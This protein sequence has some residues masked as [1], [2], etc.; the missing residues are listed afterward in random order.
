M[1]VSSL[2]VAVEAVVGLLYRCSWR[3]LLRPLSLLKEEV[4]LDA[5]WLLEKLLLDDAKR[6]V[7]MSTAVGESV[8]GQGNYMK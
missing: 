1:V 3:L 7:N 5:L 6:P 8:G 2:D 4:G